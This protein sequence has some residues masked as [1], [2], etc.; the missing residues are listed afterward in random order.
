MALNYVLNDLIAKLTARINQGTT[1]VLRLHLS[2]TAPVKLV[3]IRAHYQRI[4]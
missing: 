1:A 3:A 4:I 2:G